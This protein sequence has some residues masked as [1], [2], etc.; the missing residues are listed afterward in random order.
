MESQ[1][2]KGVEYG[3][4]II[5]RTAILSQ[6]VACFLPNRV[7]KLLFPFLSNLEYSFLF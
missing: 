4:K 6:I 2:Q 1:L 5:L 7:K 3:D